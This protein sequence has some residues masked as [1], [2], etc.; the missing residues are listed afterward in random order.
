MTDLDLPYVPCVECDQPATKFLDKQAAY[1][2]YCP[3]H[4]EE[5][6]FVPC[7]NCSHEVAPDDLFD[8]ETSKRTMWEPAEY[9]TVCR[10]CC[11]ETDP[12]PDPDRWRDDCEGP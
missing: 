3:I 11:P 2:P 12:E 6:G 5:A 10:F 9:D 1:D 7:P 8:I 4:F